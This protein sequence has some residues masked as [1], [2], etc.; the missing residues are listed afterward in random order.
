MHAFVQV[1]SLLKQSSVE[2][3]LQI[4][5]SVRVNPRRLTRAKLA[6]AITV[7]IAPDSPIKKGDPD[8]KLIERIRATARQVA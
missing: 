3:L 4:A 6:C 7:K 5:K 1:H 2:E 8:R